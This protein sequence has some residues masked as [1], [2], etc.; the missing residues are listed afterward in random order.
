MLTGK[1]Q[2]LLS[3]VLQTTRFYVRRMVQ[4]LSCAKLCAT[5]FW[6]TL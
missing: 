3:I 6:N 4:N 2:S 1:Q 5:F